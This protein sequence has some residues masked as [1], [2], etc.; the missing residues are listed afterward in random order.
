MVERE[1]GEG[2]LGGIKGLWRGEKVRG[3]G[4]GGGVVG[5]LG[6]MMRGVGWGRGRGFGLLIMGVLLLVVV[7][8]L[9]GFGER[10]GEVRGCES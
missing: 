8:E 6:G 9:G 2:M 4:I 5:G 1:R 7:V 10:G 3:D